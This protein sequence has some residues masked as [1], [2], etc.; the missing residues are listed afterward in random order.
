MQQARNDG[1]QP[2]PT[3]DIAIFGLNLP[4]GAPLAL[5]ET[6]FITAMAGIRLIVRAGDLRAVSYSPHTCG[7]RGLARLRLTASLA[8]AVLA[9]RRRL[10]C[11][12]PG[13]SVDVWRTLEERRYV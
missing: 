9:A 13:T 2:Q 11:F 6:A 5:V 3:C 8:S 1:Q 12:S 7:G 10:S 4:T